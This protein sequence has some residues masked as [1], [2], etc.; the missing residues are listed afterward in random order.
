MFW[1][2]VDKSLIEVDDKGVITY[3]GGPFRFQIPIG[4]TE[5]GISEWMKISL[6]IDGNPEFFDWFSALEEHLGRTEPFDSVSSPDEGVLNLKY[7]ENFTQIFDM[8]KKLC[9]E[10][11]PSLQCCQLYVIMEISKKYGP[12]RDRYGLVC[13]IYQIVYLSV[14]QE[15]MFTGCDIVE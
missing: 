14:P 4:Y 12:F 1:N 7:V 10:S 11:V 5:G 15:C 3:A 6:K 13:K 2:E 8:N 9:F